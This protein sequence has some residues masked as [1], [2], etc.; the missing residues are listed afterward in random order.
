M[1]VSMKDFYTVFVA[2]VIITSSLFILSA[3]APKQTD[4]WGELSKS[5]PIQR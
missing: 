1:G 4:Y 5:I 3:C 2:A